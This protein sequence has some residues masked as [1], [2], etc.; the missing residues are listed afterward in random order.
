MTAGYLPVLASPLRHGP[1]VAAGASLVVTPI[2][3]AALAVLLERRVPR[4][5]QQFVALAYGD[6]LL[7]ISVGLGVWLM[8]GRAPGGAAALP[9]GLASLC[10]GLGFGL[11]QWRAELR[12][13]FYLRT[14]AFSPTKICHQLVVY[15]VL[16]YWIWTAD[17]GGLFAPGAPAS[18]WTS[19]AKAGI[20]GCILA[21]LAANVYDRRHPKLGHPPYDWRHLRTY[22]RPWPPGSVSLR[23]YLDQAAGPAPCAATAPAVQPEHGLA[24]RGSG[25][26]DV[27]RGT[28]RAGESTPGRPVRPFTSSYPGHDRPCETRLWSDV[29]T[30]TT[31]GR[32]SRVG[33]QE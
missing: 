18:T 33:G 4:V 9:F 31:M 7:A 20:A 25:A 8:H 6:P 16:G 19:V 30:G 29:R 24:A 3:Y 17:I 14:Q 10:A 32:L 23:A 5:R 22:P 11:A 13:G 21:W 28:G 1:W 26:E 27:F 2:S 12:S 15:P